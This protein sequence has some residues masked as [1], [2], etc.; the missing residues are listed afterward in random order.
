ML[1]C[2]RGWTTAV[3]LSAIGCSGGTPS[4]TPKVDAVNPP[5]D[6]P[7]EP[8][9]EPSKPAANTP[10]CATKL[11][12][13]SSTS[14]LEEH[15]GHTRVDDFH[16]KIDAV[17][18]EPGFVPVKATAA[19]TVARADEDHPLLYF[20][21]D[22]ERVVL[23][24][25]LAGPMQVVEATRMSAGDEAPVGVLTAAG[26]EAL[27]PARW[28]ELLLRARI[29]GTWV[30][31]GAELCVA[32]PRVEGDRTVVDVDG[33]HTYVTNEDRTEPVRFSVSFGAD[34]TVAVT[35]R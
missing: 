26:R 27:A 14:L 25:A 32:A 20:T 9:A 10:S 30:H 15:R 13:S 34:G 17:P 6:P 24:A 2:V 21:P 18:I 35:G 3:A 8:S 11:S 28:V 22:F 5:A 4:Q 12:L 29:I 33:T 31:L 1:A 19:I 16:T 23:D 7:A